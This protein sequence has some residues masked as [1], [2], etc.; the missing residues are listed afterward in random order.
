MTGWQDDKMTRWQ[1][2]KMT[3]WQDDKMTRL[4]DD[5]KTWYNMIIWWQDFKI[6]CLWALM[7]QTRNSNF[8]F[9]IYFKSKTV[10]DWLTYLLTRVKSRDA[11]A[12]KNK[13]IDREL[14]KSPC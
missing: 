12:S 2:D 5:T 8:I 9:E 7:S 14:T 1:D 11:S 6:T 13:K 10:S 3:R 4:Q